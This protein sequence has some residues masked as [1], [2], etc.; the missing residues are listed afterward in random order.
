MRRTAVLLLLLAAV[1]G[2]ARL[3]RLADLRAFVCVA[4]GLAVAIGLGVE[5]MMGQFMPLAPGYRFQGLAGA[6][7]QGLIIA[8][9]ILAVMTGR[10]DRRRWLRFGVVAGLF[11]LLVLT[12]SRGALGALIAGF[13]VWQ[14]DVGKSAGWGKRVS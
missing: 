13:S 11:V 14:L 12:G 5:V 10:A 7:S 2:A 6:N 3:F 9:L 1:A 4:F 8:I